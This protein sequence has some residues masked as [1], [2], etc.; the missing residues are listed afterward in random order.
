MIDSIEPHNLMQYPQRYNY[1]G[2]Y[3]SF[4]Y[5]PVLL[6]KNDPAHDTIL[7]RAGTVNAVFSELVQ[8]KFPFSAKVPERLENERF[9]TKLKIFRNILSNIL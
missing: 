2:G 8:D 4:F 5:Y 7:C 6:S 3:Y 9:G 1:G